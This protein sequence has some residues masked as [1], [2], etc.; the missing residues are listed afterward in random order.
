MIP[1]DTQI[2]P[3]LVESPS[4]RN[5]TLGCMVSK[6]E[7]IKNNQTLADIFVA[8]FVSLLPGFYIRDTDT[9]IS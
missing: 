2:Y 1:R 6:A 3:N 9:C 7:V 4:G 5:L 8:P